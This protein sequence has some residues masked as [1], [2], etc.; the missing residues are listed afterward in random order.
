VHKKLYFRK[1]THKRKERN[2]ILGRVVSQEVKGMRYSGSWQVQI[3]SQI[4]QT[5]DVARLQV[6][7]E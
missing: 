2:Y 7:T 5:N 4:W 1:H 3:G 6:V